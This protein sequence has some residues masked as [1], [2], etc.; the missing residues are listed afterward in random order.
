MVTKVSLS[1]PRRC[2]TPAKVLIFL[3]GQEVVN[4]FNLVTLTLVVAFYERDINT[5][6]RTPPGLRDRMNKEGKEFVPLT[7]PIEIDISRCLRIH[8]RISPDVEGNEE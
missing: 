6:R 5:K 3:C 8:L 1:P 2:Q 7:L 4:E